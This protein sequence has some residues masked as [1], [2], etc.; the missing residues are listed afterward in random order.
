MDISEYLYFGFYDQ[1][2]YRDN[3]GLGPEL[4]GRWLGVAS[5]HGNL[6]CYHILNQ[7]GEVVQRSTVWRVTQL[8]LQ[9]DALKKT[10]DEYDVSIKSKL[11]EKDRSYDGA[12]HDPEDWADLIEHDQYCSDEFSRIFNNPD[13]QEADDFT[14]EVIS[15]LKY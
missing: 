5:T 15:H 7:N 8:E 11:N 3:A 12:K 2:W 9:T 10:F 14:P 4:P 1:V 13:I 6:M